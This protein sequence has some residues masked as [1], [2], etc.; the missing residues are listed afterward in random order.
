MI[1]KFTDLFL[2]PFAGLTATPAAG[3]MVLEI[4]TLIALVIYALIGWA[5]ERLIWVLFYRERGPIEQVTQ[6]TSSEQH[7]DQQQPPK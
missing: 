3:G 7:T 6:T 4:S 2:W 5:I 1:Y